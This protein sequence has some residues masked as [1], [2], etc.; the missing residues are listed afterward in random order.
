MSYTKTIWTETTAITPSRL[1]QMEDGIEQAAGQ[2]ELDAHIGSGGVSHALSTQSLAGFMSHTDKS[3]LDGIAPGAQVNTVTSV[4][5]KT[6]AVTLV[7]ADVGLAQ[8]DNTSDASKP[9]ST[10]T[11]E[12]LDGKENILGTGT[13][14][15][16]LRGDKVWGTPPNTTYSA[17]SVAE[18]QAGT[19]TSS[20]TMRA[21][22]LAQIIQHHAQP[23][24][25]D[26]NIDATLSVK[27]HVQN[28]V[29]TTT[30]DTSWSGS[31]APFSKVQ[32]VTGILSTDV[33]IIDV[34][35]SGTFA[36]DEARIEAWS[37]IYRA[38]TSSHSVTFYATKKPIVSLPLQL[39]VVR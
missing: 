35:M 34:V 18:A 17:M 13:T 27:G 5:S 30:L 9:V 12:A 19:A 1:N 4:A 20:R 8:V 25:D 37:G 24:V 3:K 26:H 6:G 11:Q 33:P 22:R 39:K 31:S 36:T 32:T 2:T 10:A 16:Y 28:G 38:V 14:S 15:Q 23:L 29:Y 7:K 21:D